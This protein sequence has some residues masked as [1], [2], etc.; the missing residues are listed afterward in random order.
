MIHASPYILLASY[1]KSLQQFNVHT[2]TDNVYR[3]LHVQCTCVCTCIYNACVAMH[4][5][6]RQ[7][8]VQC[9][10]TCVQE[11]AAVKEE[12]EKLRN[13]RTTMDNEIHELTENLFEVHN[14]V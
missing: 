5:C 10:T 8:R 13:V 1:Y 3:C 9:I 11:L 12:N 14:N 4:F 7:C 2:H 6:V